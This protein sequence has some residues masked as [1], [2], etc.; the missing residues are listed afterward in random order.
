MFTV[1]IGKAGLEPAWAQC[2]SDFKSEMSNQFHHSPVYETIIT[3]RVLMVNAPCQD[4]T[5]LSSV[6]SRVLSPES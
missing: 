5:D 2:P 3:Q 1:K 4:R 6:M